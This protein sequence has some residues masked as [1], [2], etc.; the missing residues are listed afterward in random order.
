MENQSFNINEQLAKLVNHADRLS[1]DGDQVKI[2]LISPILVEGDE[3][4]HLTLKEP[5]TSDLRKIDS[6][7]GDIAKQTTLIG[8]C[9]GISVLDV[10]RL[11]VRDF[12]LAG[13]VVESFFGEFLEDGAI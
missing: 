12:I 1:F 6:V 11:K 9:A 13:K 10:G 8:L 4:A 3:T 7:D 2:R 5:T